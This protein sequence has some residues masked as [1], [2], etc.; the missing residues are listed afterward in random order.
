MR[1]LFLNRYAGSFGG[2]ESYMHRAARGLS[3]RGTEC[4]LGRL[5]DR[6]SGIEAYLS[7]FSASFRC[8]DE[9]ALADEAGRLR[10][11]VVFLHK[12]GNTRAFLDLKDR[13]RLVRYVHDHDLCCPRRHKYYAWNSRICERPASALCWLDAGFVERRGRRLALK[14]PSAFFD[15]L[16]ANR[17]LDLLL[18]GSAWMR[19]ELLMNEFDP[20]RVAILPPSTPAAPSTAAGA[21]RRIE[22]F[23]LYVGQLIRGKGVDLLLDSFALLRRDR[24]G[25]RL[26]VAG[27]GNADGKLREKA[28]GLGLDDCVDFRGQVG[29]AE[30]DD[31]YARAALLAVPSRWPE[32]FGMVGLEAMRRGLPV[33]AFAAGGIPDWLED[34]VTGFLA[35]PGDPRSLAEAIGKILADLAAA[36]ILGE[37]GRKKAENEFPFSC[38]MDALN[39]YLAGEKP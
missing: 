36:A 22:P 4:I 19:D 11:D 28:N 14:S 2:V 9:A 37:S 5:E 10:P 33:A 23:I 3:D 1:V 21:A 7:P 32:P 6:G 12:L 13:P 8:G 39:L 30:L 38:S 20:A 24:P 34:G 25:L 26:V 29:E 16:A 27:S 31:L 17:C 35:K 18:V 15:E